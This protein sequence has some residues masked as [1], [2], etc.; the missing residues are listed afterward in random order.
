MNKINNLNLYALNY[1][2]QVE[3]KPD[4]KAEE[5]QAPLENAGQKKAQTGALLDAMTLSGVQNMTFAGINRIN[6]KDYLD[7]ASI[8]RIQA[9]MQNFT[10]VVDSYTNAVQAELPGISANQAQAL[11]LRAVMKDV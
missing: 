6:P 3:K 2:N 4:K 1:Q 10:G 5:K 9:S 11:A 8:A 7:D